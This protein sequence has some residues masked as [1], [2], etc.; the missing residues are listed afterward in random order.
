M[1]ILKL[2]KIE[3]QLGAAALVLSLAVLF[4]FLIQAQWD[5]Y[6]FLGPNALEYFNPAKNM[7]EHGVYSMD[8]NPP[9][10]PSRFRPPLWSWILAPLY[11]AFGANGIFVLMIFNAIFFAS[12]TVLMYRLGKKFLP[13]RFAVAGAVLL[14]LDQMTLRYTASPLADTMAVLLILILMLLIVRTWESPT[15]KNAVVLG[16]TMSLGIYARPNLQFLIVPA[17]AALLIRAVG[18][19]KLL[20]TVLLII[21][22]FAPLIPWQIRNYQTFGNTHFSS[23]DW[24]YLYYFGAPYVLGAAEGRPWREVRNESLLPRILAKYPAGSRV[25]GELVELHAGGFV[26]GSFLVPESISIITKYPKAIAGVA[27]LGLTR[28]FIDDGYHELAYALFPSGTRSTGVYILITQGKFGAAVKD[29]FGR[30]APVTIAL[31]IGK[32]LWVILYLGIV[33]GAIAAVRKKIPPRHGRA[34]ALIFIL[35]LMFGTTVLPV[36][37]TRHRMLYQPLF[38]LWGVTGWAAYAASRTKHKALTG[39]PP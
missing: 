5:P 25:H 27:A 4:L 38:Y 39:S 6:A 15:T 3:K 1:S 13:E 35:L 19:K 9:F 2:T 36:T 24:T 18:W 28:F 10:S 31:I 16:L 32:A 14:I 12:S 26:V 37:E 23:L 29:L 17:M 8:P 20:I 11:A 30:D 21:F 7:V 22:T 34:L 33:L